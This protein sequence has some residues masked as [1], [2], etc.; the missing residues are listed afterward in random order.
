MIVLAG[1]NWLGSPQHLVV[2][3]IFAAAVYW[4]ARRFELPE[5]GAFVAAVG[6]VCTA[7]IVVE[8]LEYPLLYGSN[9]SASA[10]YDT[11]SDMA[12][13]VVGALVGAALAIPLSRRLAGDAPP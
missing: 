5:W 7:E 3:A 2:G 9:G 11:L 4:L 8:L 10:Y 12:S 13:S 6:V 1:P